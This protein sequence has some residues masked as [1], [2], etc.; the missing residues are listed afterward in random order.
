MRNHVVGT[1]DCNLN[2]QIRSKNN[3]HTEMKGDVK[4]AGWQRLENTYIN[5]RISQQ[6]WI[7]MQLI[8]CAVNPRENLAMMLLV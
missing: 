1:R 3:D 5:L 8:V 6:L 2:T 4:Y 7:N